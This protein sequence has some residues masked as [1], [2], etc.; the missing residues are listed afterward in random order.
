VGKDRYFFNG[1][2]EAGVQTGVQTLVWQS[3][4]IFLTF[5]RI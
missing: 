1:C 5:G 3:S 4:A 2:P